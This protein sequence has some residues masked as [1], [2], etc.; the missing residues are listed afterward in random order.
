[1]VK[2]AALTIHRVS[3]FICLVRGVSS[4]AVWPSMWAIFPIS[5]SPPV[6]V[7]TMTALP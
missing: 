1:M 3:A 7:T 2:P 6:P 5:V 4:V